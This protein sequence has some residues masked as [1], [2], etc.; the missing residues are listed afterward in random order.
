MVVIVGVEDGGLG[1]D[2]REEAREAGLSTGGRA[3]ESDEE[4]CGGGC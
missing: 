2:A 3:G 1:E 4:G